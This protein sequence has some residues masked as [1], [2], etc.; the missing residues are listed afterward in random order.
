MA[1][2]WL[3]KSEPSAYSYEQ[4]RSDGRSVWDG[5]RNVEARKHLRSMAVGDLALYYH[6]GKERAVVGVA[7]VV[8]AA[9]PDPGAPEGEDW[10][11]VDIAP[12]QPMTAPVTL[13]TIKADRVLGDIALVRRGRLS[14]VP[15]STAHFGRILS[16]GKTKLSTS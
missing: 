4:L 15:L 1:Q 14:V 16:L 6:T 5:I 10:S 3:L 7:R 8:R 12:V 13:A 9:Y 11:A 2:H